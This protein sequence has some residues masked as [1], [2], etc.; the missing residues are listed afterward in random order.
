LVILVRVRSADGRSNGWYEFFDVIVSIVAWH[1]AWGDRMP[2]ETVK[3]D[4]RRTKSHK[5]LS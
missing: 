2:S 5:S 3:F 4:F 1:P